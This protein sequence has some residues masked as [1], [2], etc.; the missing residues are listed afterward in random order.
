[1][2][3][4]KQ[5][6][7]VCLVI[8]QLFVIYSII[9]TINRVYKPINADKNTTESGIHFNTDITEVLAIASNLNIKLFIVEP[10]RLVNYLNEEDIVLLDK[11]DNSSHIENEYSVNRI[12]F[13]VFESKFNISN[14]QIV[15]QIKFFLI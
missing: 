10:Q 2:Q 7:F 15:R 6:T 5:L 11:C 9:K 1:M 8:T 14:N 4:R 12:Q 13:G 3:I